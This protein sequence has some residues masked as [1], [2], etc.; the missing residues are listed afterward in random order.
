[1]K[2]LNS[3]DFGLPKRIKLVPLSNGH[4]A[5]LKKRKSRIIMKD[6]KQILEIA[7]KIRDDKSVNSVS[8]IITGPICSKTIKFLESN[9]IEIIKE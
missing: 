9:S 2:E 7:E 4:L 6:G 3:E 5:I 8:L 1:M